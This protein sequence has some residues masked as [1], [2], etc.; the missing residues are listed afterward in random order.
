M[1]NDANW[2]GRTPRSLQES[3]FG[4]YATWSAYRKTPTRRR[5]RAV[6]EKTLWAV[7]LTLAFGVLFNLDRVGH[8][9]WSYL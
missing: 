3:R 4:P 8:L 2:T 6:A 7:G 5:I 9:L 1:R